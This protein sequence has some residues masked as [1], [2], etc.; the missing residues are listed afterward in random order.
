M[1]EPLDH[2]RFQPADALLT[3]LSSALLHERSRIRPLEEV[4]AGI[5]AHRRTHY[6]RGSVPEPHVNGRRLR[7]GIA[8]AFL[9]VASLTGIAMLVL[10]S[11]LERGPVDKKGTPQAAMVSDWKMRGYLPRRAPRRT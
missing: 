8:S 2:R 5:L 4:N 3:V 6:A 1:A 11:E 10:L 7:V 9:S